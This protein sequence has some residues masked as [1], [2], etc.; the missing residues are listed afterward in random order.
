[1]ADYVAVGAVADVYV[2]YHGEQDSADSSSGSDFEDEIVSLTDCEPDVVITAAEPAESDTYLLITDETGVVREVI[3]SP[4]K[5][6]TSSGRPQ[7]HTVAGH[8]NVATAGHDNVAAGHDVVATG[9]DNVTEGP[10][11]QVL[12]PSQHTVAAGHDVAA[13][14]HDSASDSDSDFVY[15]P[16]SDDSGEDS[17]VVELRRHARKFKKRMRDSKSWI[18]SDATS[19]VPIDLIANMEQ[20][21]EAKQDDW[22]YDSSDEDYSYDEDSDGELVKRKSQFIRYNNDTEIPHFALSMVFRSKNQFCKALRRY[23]LVTKR[24]IRFIKSESDRV[25]AKCGWDGCPWLIYAAK[26][27]RTA[28][29]QVIT[30]ND[31]H[32]CAQN[33]VNKL[34]T[35]KLVAQR[36]E[37]FILANPM[38]KIES[39]KKKNAH[40]TKTT[41]KNSRNEQASGSGTAPQAQ[42]SGSA[43]ASASATASTSATASAR[44]TTVPQ[45]SAPGTKASRFKPPRKRVATTEAGPSTSGVTGRGAKRG[46]RKA[47]SSIP[48]YSYFTC[49]GNY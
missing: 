37:H 46:R 38:W 45:A 35:A 29:F 13:P 40:L 17:E 23:G 39:M 48:S 12:D 2:E 14:E 28:R 47:A 5:H 34:V 11:S 1:M 6:R 10:F 18:G 21:I 32:E 25:R 20:Q 30:F 16:H 41:K 8:D 27:S 3:S 24:S 19:A 49:S 9:H 36:Y 43:T 22:K 4:Q 33:R 42:A 26:R 31:H 44:T 15:I 7:K